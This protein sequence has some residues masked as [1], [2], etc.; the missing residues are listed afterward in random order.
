[1]NIFKVFF[2]IF[3]VSKKAMN[4]FQSDFFT[5]LEVEKAFTYEIS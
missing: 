3:S 2:F 5:Y 1:M 4:I